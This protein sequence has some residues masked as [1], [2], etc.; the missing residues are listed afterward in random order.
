MARECEICG[1][2]TT[3]GNQYARRGLAKAKGGVGK[4]VTGKNKRKF[5]PNLQKV[6]AVVGG[7][8]R[9]LRVCTRC[10]KSGKL[11]KPVQ[12]DRFSVSTTPTADVS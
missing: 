8:V 11:V 5:H 2:K 1:K 3:V 4:K 12:R 6:R 7:T 9:R 10:I